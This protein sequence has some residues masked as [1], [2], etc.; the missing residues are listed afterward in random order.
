TVNSYRRFWGPGF[1]GPPFSPRGYQKRTTARRGSAPGRVGGRAGDAPVNPC[2]SFA[3]LTN[4]MVTRH[5]SNQRP[6]SPTDRNRFAAI[7]GGKDVK[8]VPMTLGEAL[9]AL[10]KDTLVQ[11]AMPGD[12]Y[13]VF[14]HYKTDEWERFCAAVS[15]WDIAEYL[16]I[17]P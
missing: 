16:D 14:R 15:D 1:L 10:E 12:M 3:P 5:K 11:D 17:M 8:K 13:R 2:L 9:A 4:A 6:Q 7:A